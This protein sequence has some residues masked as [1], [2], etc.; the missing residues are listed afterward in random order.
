MHNSL[1]TLLL[2]VQAAF[3]CM[4]QEK[5]SVPRIRIAQ[6]RRAVLAR[7]S[8]IVHIPPSDK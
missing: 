3:L 6:E 8:K 4:S 2:Q 5:E 1:C 7:L